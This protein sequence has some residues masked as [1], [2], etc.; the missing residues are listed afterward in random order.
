MKSSVQAI[1][2][3]QGCGRLQPVANAVPFLIGASRPNSAGMKELAAVDVGSAIA[4]IGAII[5]FFR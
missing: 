2:R 4:A 3:A 1:Q 5:A